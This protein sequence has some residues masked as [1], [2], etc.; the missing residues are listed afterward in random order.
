MRRVGKILLAVLLLL[1]LGAGAMAAMEP[2]VAAV[3]C[4]RCFG[5]ERLQDSIFVDPA[6]PP[7]QRRD[8][9]EAVTE[10]ER[11]A[12]SFLGS[13]RER[14]VIFA[15]ASAACSRRMHEGGARAV[16]YAQYGLHLS[17]I[18]LDVVTIAHE[19]THIEAHGRI[20]LVRLLTGALPAWF[21]EGLAVL[22]SD[23]RRYLKPVGSGDRCT[24]EPIQTLPI[25]A[26][27]WMRRAGADAMLYARAACRVQRWAGTHGGRD[28][29]MRLID[30]VGAGNSFDA[31]WND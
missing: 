7:D 26:A 23:D 13:L 10:G 12:S 21:D 2:A 17:P 25:T 6:M 30:G 20:G 27:D 19:L 1:V 28:G 8:F 3:A 31:L 11:R 4:P 29:L 16:S 5:F 9:L 18:G 15:C 14:P 24:A 22:A